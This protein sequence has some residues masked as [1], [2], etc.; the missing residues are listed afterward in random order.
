MGPSVDLAVFKLQL[1][2]RLA[3]DMNFIRS[4]QCFFFCKRLQR[5][6]ALEIRGITIAVTIRGNRHSIGPTLL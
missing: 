5:R 1:H 2:L 6:L 4:S 3:R